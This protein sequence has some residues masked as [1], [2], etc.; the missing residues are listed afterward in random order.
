MK[1]Q[2]NPHQAGRPSVSAGRSDGAYTH[3]GR[4]SEPA[5]GKQPFSALETLDAL[6][7]WQ[8]G[9]ET[10][11][12]GKVRWAAD[13]MPLKVFVEP[14]A[15]QKD[16]RRL[17]HTALMQWEVAS[18][19]AVRFHLLDALPALRDQADIVIDWAAETTLGR[20]YEVGHTDRSIQGVYITRATMTLIQTP[21]IDA[22]LSPEQQKYR[23]FSTLLHEVGHALGLEH[24]DRKEDVMHHRGWRHTMLSGNDIKR[25]QA[26]YR[27]GLV[28]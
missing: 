25:I 6:A 24:S 5:P 28:T 15:R 26:L 22:H 14:D 18:E 2:P 3:P 19:G 1:I 20:D 8:A 12:G 17:L 21:V 16:V 10:P 27:T 23:L 9:E 7:Q 4:T 11:Q 13:K